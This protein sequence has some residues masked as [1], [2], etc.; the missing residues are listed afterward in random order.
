MTLLKL[1]SLQWIIKTKKKI[2]QGVIK[3]DKGLFWYDI[4][5]GSCSIEEAERMGHCGD[6]ARGRLYLRSKEKSKNI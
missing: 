6:D 3:Y 1:L 4:G 2:R 5:E